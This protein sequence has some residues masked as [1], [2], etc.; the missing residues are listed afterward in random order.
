[1][2][3]NGKASVERKLHSLAAD[4]FATLRVRCF[5]RHPFVYYTL[6]EVLQL[7]LLFKYQQK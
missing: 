5:K 1:M 2:E 7:S 6:T 3:M 4:D